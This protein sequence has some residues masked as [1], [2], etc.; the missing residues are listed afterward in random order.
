MRE[1]E[2]EGE[3]EGE[4]EEEQAERVVQVTVASTNCWGNVKG[5]PADNVPTDTT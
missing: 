5:K 1:G 4:E 2:G 3:G